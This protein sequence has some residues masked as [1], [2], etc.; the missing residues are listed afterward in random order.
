DALDQLTIDVAKSR[1]TLADASS[2]L[3]AYDQRLYEQQVKGFEQSLEQLRVSA[4]PKSKFAFKRK[5]A[6]G[7]S[8]P[9]TTPQAATPT[10]TAAPSDVRALTGHTGVYLTS[11]S[12]PASSSLSGSQ[13]TISDIDRCIIDL[14]SSQ[15]DDTLTAMHM[16]NVKNSILLLPLLSG[17]VILLDLH[18]TILVVGCHQFRMHSSTHV[19]VYLS[20]SSNPIIEH[21][22]DIQFT[23]YPSSFSA[24]ASA[25]EATSTH[26]SVQDF[27]HIR[28][29]PSPHWRPLPENAVIGDHSWP[30][31]PFEGDVE[32]V[33]TRLLP[34]SAAPQQND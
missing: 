12:L 18:N 15:D 28:A 20:I 27:S 7:Q 2:F 33:L 3:P 29:T 25:N 23:S 4:A 8:N 34:Q 1:K 26:L 6:T 30:T 10:T 14:R 13:L 24:S 31:A 32:T 17:S 19:N 16:K 5:T 9:K 21:C 22:S 11:S